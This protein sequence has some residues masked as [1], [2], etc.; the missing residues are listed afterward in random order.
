M[1]PYLEQ[2]ALYEQFHLDEPWDSE[3]NKTL[4]PKMPR[5]FQHFSSKNQASDG[6]SNF[7]VPTGPGLAFESDMEI[8]FGDFKD[9]SSN[10]V[11]IMAVDDEHAEV[12]TKPV[13]QNFDPQN[14]RAGLYL[15]PLNEFLFGICDGSVDLMKNTLSDDMLRAWMTRDGGEVMHIDK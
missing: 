8:K 4:I 13:G 2:Q 6:L 10:T 3:H 9:G 1:L 14:P 15:S 7:V 12:W 5:I 11:L